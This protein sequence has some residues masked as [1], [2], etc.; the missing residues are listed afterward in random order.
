MTSET[1]TIQI[2]YGTHEIP[3]EVKYEERNQLAITVRPDMT[4]EARAPLGSEPERVQKKLDEKARWVWQQLDHFEKYQPLQPPREYVGGETHLYLGRQYRLKIEG[5]E[6]EK[7]RLIGKFFVVET[8]DT[9][10]RSAVKEL[11]LNW[12]QA[13]AKE[14]IRRKIEAYL[15]DVERYGAERPE[16]RIQWMKKRWGSCT[17]NGVMTINIE[18]VKA[19]IHCVEYVLMHELC[20]LVYPNHSPDFYQLLRMLMPDWPARKERLE[21]VVV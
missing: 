21:K 15:P 14:L 20:H 19:P 17:P 10:D 1:T 11:M 9:S 13:H 6:R 12:Y 3:I 8:R 18:L 16:V 7:V 4:V 5:S 2:F